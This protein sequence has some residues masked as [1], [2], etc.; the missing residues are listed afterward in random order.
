M[1]A[2]NQLTYTLAIHG[3]A[4]KVTR[5]ELSA[6]KE[7][8]VRQGLADALWAGENI[9]KSGGTAIEA[10]EASVRSLEDNSLFNAGK[11]SVLTHEGNCEMDAAVMDGKTLQAGAV[12]CVS[13]IKNP[14]SLARAVMEQS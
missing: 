7:A 9:L 12:A 5:E 8:R 11:G 13:G 3:G 10:V 4:G 1:S 2:A 14:V 6:E